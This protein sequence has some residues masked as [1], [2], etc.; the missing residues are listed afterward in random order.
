M[1][2][3][4]NHT[5]PQ[6]ARWLHVALFYILACPIVIFG[7]GSVLLAQNGRPKDTWDKADII[8]KAIAGMAGVLIPAVIAYGIHKYDKRQA[9]LEHQRRTNEFN[10]QLYQRAREFLP[11]LSSKDGLDEWTTISLIHGLSEENFVAK[12]AEYLV[13]KHLQ[14]QDY[15]LIQRMTEHSDPYIRNLAANALRS[16]SAVPSKVGPPPTAVQE[17]HYSNLS[18]TD[19]IANIPKSNSRTN[20]SITVVGLRAAGRTRSRFTKSS[21]WALSLSP[22]DSSWS[23]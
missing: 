8:M 6:E 3:D 21:A 16:I 9:K 17:I 1:E 10:L 15:A 20:R 4:S 19:V 13:Q 2:R 11:Q 14:E 7:T 5:P 22:M 23:L 18:T 12:I